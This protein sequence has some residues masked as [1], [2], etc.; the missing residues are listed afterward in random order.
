MRLAH[1]G[2]FALLGALAGCGSAQGL[3][4][5]F[6]L[7]ATSVSEALV[8]DDFGPTFAST[9][10]WSHYA[11]SADG[12]CEDAIAQVDKA[13][14]TLANTAEW[15]GIVGLNAYAETNMA[16]TQFVAAGCSTVGQEAAASDTLSALVPLPT[17]CG[18]L[19]QN[20]L[21]AWQI[22]TSVPAYQ[23]LVADG[24]LATLEQAFGAAESSHCVY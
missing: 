22:V 9:V 12:G 24:T 15:N 1:A 19:R 10:A 8:W 13:R 16:W 5:K 18:V 7:G 21:K 2:Y 11:K 3:D 14:A 17:K 23:G 6:D 4:S 20:V